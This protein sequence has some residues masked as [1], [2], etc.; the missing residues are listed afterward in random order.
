MVRNEKTFP[1]RNFLNFN[2]PCIKNHV[3]PICYSQLQ[4][5]CTLA[6]VQKGVCEIGICMTG[7]SLSNVLMNFED[8]KVDF[9]V[10]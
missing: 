7:N 2:H 8:F 6:C 5:L 1:A 9:E 3:F 4:S 10:Y